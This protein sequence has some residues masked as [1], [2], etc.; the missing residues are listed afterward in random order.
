[1]RMTDIEKRVLK[2][3]GSAPIPDLSELPIRVPRPR[4]ANLVT[5]FYFEISPRTLERW[6]LAWQR[7][8][9]KAHCSTAELFAVAEAKLTEAPVL[10]GG[11]RPTTSQR[12]ATQ[13]A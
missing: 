13:N 5:Q 1:M 11:C 7:L 10:M 3:G 12:T 4:A 8:N 6:P 2:R 9:G